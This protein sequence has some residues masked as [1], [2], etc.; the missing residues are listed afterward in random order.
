MVQKDSWEWLLDGFKIDL[1]TQVKPKTV[2]DYCSHIAYFVRWAES[3]CKI[4]PRSI[5]KRDIQ[6]FLHYIASTPAIFTTGNGAKRI[7][8]RDENSRWH[9]YFPLKRFF[10]WAVDEGY[11]TQNPIDTIVLKPPKAAPIEPYGAEHI[12]IFFKILEHEWKNATTILQK[13]LAARNRAILSLFLDSFVRLEEC[14]Y[15]KTTDVDLSRKRVMVRKSKT[16]KPRIAGFGP[17]TKKA[18]WQY[19]GFR[20]DDLGHDALWITEEGRPLGKYGIQ[21]IIRR[22]KRDAGLQ[23]LKGS[24]HKL[25]HTGATVTLKHTRDMKGLKLLLGHSTLAMTERYT[26]FIEAEDALKAYDGQGPLD[27]IN[28]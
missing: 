3:N 9:H 18:L 8:Q 2:K 13:M 25:R 20:G 26:Q 23:G 4:T 28:E 27:W 16:D 12:D 10:A 11:L 19:L 24:V 22:L 1:E 14:C 7:V 17:Q 15:L 21:V 6:E 5:I